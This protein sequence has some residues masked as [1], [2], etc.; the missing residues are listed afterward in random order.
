LGRGRPVARISTKPRRRDSSGDGIGFSLS[1][2]ERAG[3]RGNE[4]LEFAKRTGLS[5][6]SM[7]SELKEFRRL[8]E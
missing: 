3:V 4:T 2:G 7:L 1:P 5:T 8:H 6:D